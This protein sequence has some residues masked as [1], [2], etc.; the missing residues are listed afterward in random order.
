[1][2][3]FYLVFEGDETPYKV[4]GPRTTPFPSSAT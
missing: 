3:T 1:M 2:N 4:T